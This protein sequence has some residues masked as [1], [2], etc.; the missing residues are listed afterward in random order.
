MD[1]ETLAVLESA[2][3]GHRADDNLVDPDQ[4]GAMIILH[5]SF[6]E[7]MPEFPLVEADPE[8]MLGPTFKR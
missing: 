6:E 7:S 8:W 2:V 4:L 3:R 5:R 1:P